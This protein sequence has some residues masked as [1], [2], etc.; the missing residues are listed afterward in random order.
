LWPVEGG[1]E[2]LVTEL[3]CRLLDTA[4]MAQEYPEE[5]A[6]T[7][8]GGEP[9][10]QAEALAYLVACLK[11]YPAHVIVYTGYVVEDLLVMAEALPEIRRALDF[12]DVL[13]D[14]PYEQRL[15]SPWM[16]YRGSSNQRV[17]DM[18]A[19][20]RA[21]R[22]APTLG[23]S[24]SSPSPLPQGEGG[25]VLLDWDTPELVIDPQGMVLG[26][27]PV[28]AIFAE[29]GVVGSSRRCGATDRS[30]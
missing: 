22:G 19:T 1:Q 13:V 24:P 2:S 17:I 8:S 29:A 4:A 10:A 16:Q 11:A 14:G 27:E 21:W 28:V 15:D 9:F 23:V 25:L 26:A 30:G 5:P 6:I 20:L 3:A 12:I 7:I 18:P